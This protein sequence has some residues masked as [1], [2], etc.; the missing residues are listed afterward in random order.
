MAEKRIYTVEDVM[1]ELE[2]SDRIESDS[3]DE[4]EG[5]I[6][7]EEAVYSGRFE[8]ICREDDWQQESDE[9]VQDEEVQDEE[10]QDEEVL[11]EVVQD[12]EVQDEE[13]QD[14]EVQDEAMEYEGVHDMENERMEYEGVRCVEVGNEGEGNEVVVGQQE[15]EKED[16]E[17]GVPLIPAYVEWP[18][19]AEDVDGERPIDL[20]KLFVTTPM[21]EHIVGQ[22]N[23][24]A[25]QHLESQDLAP[26]S[27]VRQWRNIA[28]TLQELLKFLSLVLMMGLIRLPQIE[29]H[30]STTWPY[31]TNAFSGVSSCRM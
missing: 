11:D 10:V 14:E 12:E 3:D 18:G 8:E 15:V 2:V 4:F 6:D 31:A 20:F 25:N 9:E 17:T 28:H 23:L 21:L 29:S 1:R 22:T 30:W 27:R 24:S 16:T 19:V 7:E 13:V 5:Y 26:R